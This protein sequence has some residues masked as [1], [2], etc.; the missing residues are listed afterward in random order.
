MFIEIIPREVAN[1]M[2]K[3]ANETA[4]GGR[5]ID[6]AFGYETLNDAIIDAEKIGARLLREVV[7]ENLFFIF[8]QTIQSLG[9]APIALSPV[10]PLIDEGDSIARYGNGEKS[11]CNNKSESKYRAIVLCKLKHADE[12]EK[13]LA[14]KKKDGGHDT[15]CYEIAWSE[16]Q[17][18]KKSLSSF[19]DQDNKPGLGNAKLSTDAIARRKAAWM[20]QVQR[21]LIDKLRAA[22][23]VKVAG[24][25]G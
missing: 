22:G 17:E 23:P 21:E 24:S 16:L 10:P 4:N 5:T 7:P 11:A 8:G 20:N 25:E 6:D 18:L 12:L 9:Y 3:T 19:S 15:Q 14:G 2:R 13:Y 1:V